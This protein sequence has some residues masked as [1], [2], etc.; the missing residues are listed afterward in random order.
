MCYS[1][2]ASKAIV[3]YD[4]P[5]LTGLDRKMPQVTTRTAIEAQRISAF[6]VFLSRS[7]L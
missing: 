3:W 5:T 4:A 6:P 2:T 7:S 1:A